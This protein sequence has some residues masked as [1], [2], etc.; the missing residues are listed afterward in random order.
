MEH[1][2]EWG[3]LGLFVSSFLAATIIPLSSEIVLSLLLAND[4]NF[5]TSLSLATLG[6]WLG[7]TEQLCSWSPWKLEFN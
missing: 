6:N 3:Y 5:I 2:V 7:G 1:Y 4:Y